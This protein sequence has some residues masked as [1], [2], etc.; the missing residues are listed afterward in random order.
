MQLFHLEGDDPYDKLLPKITSVISK[1]V[2]IYLILTIVLFGLYYVNG[3]SLFD[4][5]AHSFTTISTGGFSTHD[6]SFA[7]FENHSILFI[8]II[9]MILGSFPF[10]VLAKTNIK[11][12]FAAFEDHQVNIFLLLLLISACLIYFFAQKY[13][14]GSEFQKIIIISF[15]TISIISG[16]GFIS[17]NFEGWGNY[18]STLFLILMSIGGCAGSTTGGI[19]IFRFQILLKY[20]SIHLKKMLQPHAVIASHF[21]GKKI[22]DASK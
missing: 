9:F 19:K 20:I 4:A 7:Y 5:V 2:I 18:A 8:A 3:M 22:K 12:T 21:N 11:N 16:T 1:I 13:I 17:E 10:L 14:V 15:N 6:L